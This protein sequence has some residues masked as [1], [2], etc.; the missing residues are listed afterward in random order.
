MV[1]CVALAATVPPRAAASGHVPEELLTTFAVLWTAHDVDGMAVLWDSD[2]DIV[3]PYD[4]YASYV[5]GQ[6]K[7]RSLLAGEHK[8]RMRKS[9]YTV[10]VDKSNVRYL[11][12]GQKYAVVD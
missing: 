10:T 3:Y 8:G 6:E 2:G 5:R 11:D 4:P 12:P 9:T 1:V 7:I